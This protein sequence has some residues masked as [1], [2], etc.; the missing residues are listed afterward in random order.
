MCDKDKNIIL[1]GIEFPSAC[2]LNG[3][4]SLLTK[5]DEEKII[6]GLMKLAEEDPSFTVTNNSET[7]QTLING[8][9]EQHIDV[10]CKQIKEQSTA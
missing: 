5:G 4:Q 7:K 6:G 8:Q 2:A 3:G 10:T 9:G 1:T